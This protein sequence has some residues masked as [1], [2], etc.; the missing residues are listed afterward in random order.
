MGSEKGVKDLIK[1]DKKVAEIGLALI[2]FL[3]LKFKKELTL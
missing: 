3:D 1:Q 2:E